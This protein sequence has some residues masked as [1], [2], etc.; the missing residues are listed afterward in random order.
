MSTLE[1]RRRPL[2]GGARDTFFI[3]PAEVGDVDAV[4]AIEAGS[5][6]NPWQPQTFRSLIEERRA[7][8]LVAEGPASTILG[9]AVA[10]WVHE[11]GELANLAVLPDFR[12]KGVGSALLDRV[13][14]D[15]RS[16][17]V[18]SLFL[19]VRA[20]NRRAAGLYFSRGFSQVAV[21]TDY[22]RNPLEDARILL[23]R[24][25]GDGGPREVE[26]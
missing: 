23:K 15:L 2:D 24:L 25:G 16:R 6:S 26:E 19:E 21:R 4:A 7:H 22:Y 14:A 5:F 9:Y 20:S 8:I 11:Q 17:G 13:L 1:D 3:R 10:W 12:G 18:E